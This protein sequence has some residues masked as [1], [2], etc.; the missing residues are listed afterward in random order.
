[1]AKYRA[2][3]W[4]LVDDPMPRNRAR[5]RRQTVHGRV[6]IAHRTP[7]DVAGWLL[8]DK[9]PTY[10]RVRHRVHKFPSRTR[11]HYPLHPGRSAPLLF[12]DDMEGEKNERICRGYT[13]LPVHDGRGP[14]WAL[15]QD[16]VAFRAPA[17]RDTQRGRAGGQSLR[18]DDVAGSRTD[19]EFGQEHL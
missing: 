14:S 2:V 8:V 12:T 18:R 10:E 16:E 15:Q 7:R 17:G 19:V 4:V 5:D 11:A 9:R 1:M 3:I 13:R 6:A